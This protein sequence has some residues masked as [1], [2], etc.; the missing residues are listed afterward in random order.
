MLDFRRER[1]CAPLFQ[2]LVTKGYIELLLIRDNPHMIYGH[3]IDYK[4]LS[5]LCLSY[6]FLNRIEKECPHQ[7]YLV[8]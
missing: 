3:L 4:K 6:I 5:Q 8:D 7:S 2:V 1:E